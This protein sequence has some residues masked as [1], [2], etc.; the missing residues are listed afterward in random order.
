MLPYFPKQIASKAFAI[1]LAALAVVSIVFYRYAMQIPF[2]LLGIM[3]VSGF[4]FLTASCTKSWMHVREKV[5]VQNVF[6]TAFALRVVWVIFSYFFY[7][8][9]TGQPFEP[10]AADSFGYHCAA[11]WLRKES[12]SNVWHYLFVL[13]EGVSDSG[14]NFYLTILY[15]LIGP[16]IFIT[17]CLKCIYSAFTCVLIYKLTSRSIDERVGRMAAVFALFMPN[18]I[19]YCGLHLKETEMIFL[20]VAFLE[21]ADYLLRSKHYTILTVLVPLLLAGSL[22]FF[23]TVLGAVAVFSLVT[24]LFFTSD[25][26]VGRGKKVAV[27]A[28]L[29]LAAAVLAGGTIVNEVEGL[30]EDRGDNQSAKR[31]EQTLRGNQWAKYATGTV[32]APMMFVMPFSTMVDVDEQY[33]QQIIHGGNYVRNFMGFFVLVAL[34]L[35]IFVTKEWRDF[36]LIGSYTIAYLGVLAMSGFANSERFLLPALPGLIIMWAYGMTHLNGKSYSLLKYWMIV[37]FLMQVAWAYFKLGSRGL[38]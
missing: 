20:I 17:R 9:L 13:P 10:G 28:W 24:G 25:R 36:S 34:F 11:D 23:R 29:A 22:F 15:K 32:M 8:H 37:V 18:L 31:M 33:N 1:Y 35:A 16:N 5:F 21:R 12:W 2:M 19:I 14:Y 3:E 26:I 4:F 7:I 38:F 27:I 30:L 6:W